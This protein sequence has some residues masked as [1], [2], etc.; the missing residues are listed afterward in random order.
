M[1]EILKTKKTLMSRKNQYDN[2]LVSEKKKSRKEKYNIIDTAKYKQYYTTISL[3]QSSNNTFDILSTDA[4]GFDLFYHSILNK[5]IVNIIFSNEIFLTSLNRKYENGESILSIL[6][7]N[8]YSELILTYFNLFNFDTL[9][10]VDNEG[11]NMLMLSCEYGCF[12]VAKKLIES[13]VNFYSYDNIGNNFMSYAIKSNST[14]KVD[15]FLWFIKRDK[16]TQSFD[17]F[18]RYYESDIEIIGLINKKHNSNY[19]EIF[20]GKERKSSNTIILKKC[21][22]YN[23]H[24]ILSSDIIKE[25]VF[26]NTILKNTIP[27]RLLGFYLDEN[28]NFYL[29]YRPLL[30]TLCD[31]F[32]LI[33]DYEDNVDLT[34]RIFYSLRD[35]ILTIHKLGILHNDLKLEN[36]ML[37]YNGEEEIIDYGICDFFGIS[38]HKSVIKNY[39]SSTYIK[40]PDDGTKITF[41]ICDNHEKPQ[42]K[43]VYDKNTKSYHSDMYSFGVSIIQGI[44]GTTSKYLFISNTFY[45]IVNTNIPNTLNKLIPLSLNRVTELKKYCFFE[46]LK[47]LISINS[48]KRIHRDEIQCSP[49]E[50]NDINDNI[51]N[52]NIHYSSNEIKLQKKELVYMNDIINNYSNITISLKNTRNINTLLSEIILRFGTKISYD[53]L[54]NTIYSTNLYVGKQKSEYIFIAYL[55]IFSNIFEFYSY[56]INTISEILLKPVDIIIGYV[57]EIILSSFTTLNFIP[58]VTFIS[59]S[60]INLQKS[61][62]LSCSEIR[63]CEIQLINKIENA[64]TSSNSELNLNTL[65]ST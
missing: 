26:A 29:I 16:P 7:K 12:D 47:L 55:Y 44:F 9:N 62:T 38:P 53:T 20:H 8:R 56:D 54:F 59:N 10:N 21:L 57:N 32:R 39:I 28:F 65:S 35:K 4:N 58:F 42:G 30:I 45:K 24:S 17:D 48:S 33:N 46:E 61:N 18:K 23:H 63:D 1:S 3:L 27:N 49:V 5:D 6:I 22:K 19:S 36:I 11:K 43:L 60:V 25:I 15:F 31:F 64:V 40:A 34:Q 41:E 50:L 13:G 51:I 37:N 2:H 52:N 14:L